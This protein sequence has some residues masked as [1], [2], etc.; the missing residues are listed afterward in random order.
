MRGLRWPWVD[1]YSVDFLA[2]LGLQGSADRFYE[3]LAAAGHLLDDR[4][5]VAL[6][7]RSSLGDEPF[8]ESL[9]ILT[10]KLSHVP[11]VPVLTGLLQRW[12]PAHFVKPNDLQGDKP[13][14]W[15]SF[16][17]LS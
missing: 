2:S 3:A 15:R 4:L 11:A 14:T 6:H 7:Q 17:R 16:I 10:C 9:C 5:A 1:S 12:V 13:E 8:F